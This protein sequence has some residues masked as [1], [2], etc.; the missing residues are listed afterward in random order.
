MWRTTI[1]EEY[2]RPQPKAPTLPS[3]PTV[4]PKAIPTQRWQWMAIMLY[5][6]MVLIWQNHMNHTISIYSNFIVNH[7]VVCYNVASYHVCMVKFIVFAWP[8]RWSHDRNCQMWSHQ[9]RRWQ[10]RDTWDFTK[11]NRFP[12]CSGESYESLI[13]VQFFGFCWDS[14]VRE[15]VVVEP[16]G[17][18]RIKAK[19]GQGE[20]DG[21]TCRWETV[22]DVVQDCWWMLKVV[23][24]LLVHR[25]LH[26]LG[27]NHISI[28]AGKPEDDQSPI[29]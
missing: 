26:F 21:E 1:L 29:L 9:H 11:M 25:S 5:G 24:T 10:I 27:A 15:E 12:W 22:R 7:V 4:Q 8:V 23:K 20:I 13:F 16:R 2:I 6:F 18:F 28:C 17:L 14:K 19:V 3:T